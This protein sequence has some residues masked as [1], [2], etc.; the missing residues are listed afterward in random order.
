MAYLF[1]ALTIGFTV[2][3]Q[4]YQKLLADRLQLEFAPAGPGDYLGLLL[5]RELLAAG[6]CLGLAMAFWL[7]ALQGLEVSKAYPM[8]AVNYVIMMMLARW[9]FAEVISL[10][11]W[12]GMLIILG[13]IALITGS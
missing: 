3:G 7:L 12:A 5:D 13:G 11:R 4:Y 1:I 2:L 6:A 9:R 10:T 8:L